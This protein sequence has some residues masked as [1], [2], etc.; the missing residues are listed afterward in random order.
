M[1]FPA[2]EAHEYGYVTKKKGRFFEGD[3]TCREK[4]CAFGW[5]AP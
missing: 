5:S 4:A 3:L 2:L 1:Y